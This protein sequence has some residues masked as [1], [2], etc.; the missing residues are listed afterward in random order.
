LSADGVLTLRGLPFT[1]GES[2]EVM[3]QSSPGGESEQARYP[4]RGTTYT[5]V[6]PFE[7][8]DEGEWEAGR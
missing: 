7:P 8:V 6:D 1:R 2:V 3:I 5:Y 4:L